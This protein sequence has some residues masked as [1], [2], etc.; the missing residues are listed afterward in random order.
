MPWAF[1]QSLM[2]QVESPLSAVH[3]TDCIQLPDLML[4]CS[5]AMIW[6][7]VLTAAV[8]VWEHL[9]LAVFGR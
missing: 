1:L 9:H 2:R 5:A 3:V 8:N 7:P 6:R 4:G